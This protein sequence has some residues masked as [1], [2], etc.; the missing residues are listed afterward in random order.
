M[1]DK[2]ELEFWNKDF[3]LATDTFSCYGTFLLEE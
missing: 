2:C 3:C 1:R